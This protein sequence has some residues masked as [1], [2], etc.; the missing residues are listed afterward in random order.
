MLGY[1]PIFL[2]FSIQSVIMR[3]NIINRIV[4]RKH[5]FVFIF[6]LRFSISSIFSQAGE[7]L[8]RYQ[9]QFLPVRYRSTISLLIFPCCQYL[10]FNILSNCLSLFHVSKF[11]VKTFNDFV[12]SIDNAHYLAYRCS[13]VTG[14][15]FEIHFALCYRKILVIMILCC[16]LHEDGY[17][18][19]N[20]RLPL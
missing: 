13:E 16:L 3:V 5:E 1:F 8:I 18:L 10:V 4:K 14:A 19:P 6:T 7:A 12:S 9:Y 20:S 2:I 11:I 15:M 17:Y